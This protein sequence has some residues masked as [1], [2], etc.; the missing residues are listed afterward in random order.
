MHRACCDGARGSEPT[1]DLPPR[2]E[3]QP[4]SGRDHLDLPITKRQELALKIELQP[5][6]A[7]APNKTKKRF[8]T[9]QMRNRSS[10][11]SSCEPS[12]AS[13]QPVVAEPLADALALTDTLICTEA[14]A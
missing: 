8:R 12:L 13:A 14:S 10:L 5:W 6:L 3:A 7:I 4:S 9:V 1:G 2:A 11:S